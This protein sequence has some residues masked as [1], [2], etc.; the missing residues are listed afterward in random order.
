MFLF[1][2]RSYVQCELTALWM[3]QG[4][5]SPE[6]GARLRASCP[7]KGKGDAC[8]Q[9]ATL[10]TRKKW[11]A[12]TSAMKVERTKAPEWYPGGVLEGFRE[13]E[14]NG[15][16]KERHKYPVAVLWR[17]SP[18]EGGREEFQIEEEVNLP[19]KAHRSCHWELGFLKLSQIWTF[20]SGCGLRNTDFGDKQG[21]AFLFYIGQFILSLQAS[22]FSLGNRNVNICFS[23]L[24]QFFWT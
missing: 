17:S 19:V 13:R 8:T 14:G 2:K 1:W 20:P 5:W 6:H 21:F 4:K 16:K 22:V 24:P 11:G 7:G 23:K 10:E 9:K 15:Q 3:S 18:L 12:P